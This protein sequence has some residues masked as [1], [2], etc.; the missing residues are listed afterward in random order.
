M[1]DDTFVVLLPLS[2]LAIFALSLTVYHYNDSNNMF[3]I[4][5]GESFLEDIH[6]Y[7]EST[8]GCKVKNQTESFFSN[9]QRKD[10][11][12]NKLSPVMGG[13]D[14]VQFFTTYKLPDGT[15]N[16]SRVGQRGLD[17]HSSIYNNYEYKFISDA[18]KR[19]VCDFAQFHHR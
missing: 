8:C 18:N 19:F 15:Y 16:E 6:D 3:L 12:F 7:G 14:M 4:G 11:C 2:I 5:G 1:R 17:Q 13:V 10:Y 9:H